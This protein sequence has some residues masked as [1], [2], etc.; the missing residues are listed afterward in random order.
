M[1]EGA[2]GDTCILHSLAHPLL[3]QP[4]HSNVT[5][6]DRCTSTASPGPFWT[7][8][9]AQMAEAPVCMR[10]RRTSSRLV[11]YHEAAVVEGDDDGGWIIVMVTCLCSY[12]GSRCTCGYV[13]W[14]NTLPSNGFRDLESWSG[15]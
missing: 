3:S 6:T 8:P 12:F 2:S 1:G 9:P 11:R 13:L 7:P 14:A 4:I 15:Q 10:P 5:P